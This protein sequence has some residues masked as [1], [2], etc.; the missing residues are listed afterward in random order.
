M[1]RKILIYIFFAVVVSITAFLASNNCDEPII[2]YDYYIDDEYLWLFTLEGENGLVHLNG[3]DRDV[4]SAKSFRVYRKVLE[5]VNTNHEC[6]EMEAA[7]K[8]VGA[9]IFSSNKLQSVLRYEKKYDTDPRKGFRFIY[10]TDLS[11]VK[12]WTIS[13]GNVYGSKEMDVFIGAYFDSMYNG[14]GIRPYFMTYLKDK[15]KLVRKWTGSYMNRG[16]FQDAEFV[17]LA[18]R[19]YDLLLVDEKIET[20]NGGFDRYSYY[21]YY[22]FSPWFY[23]SVD[24]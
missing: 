18:G 22:N 10:E 20:A 8:L 16:S 19:E 14:L 2:D 7:E 17:R 23:K 6:Y 9:D 3:F 15:N 12:P 5:T 13:A 4:M 24:K 21:S 11:L 1:K